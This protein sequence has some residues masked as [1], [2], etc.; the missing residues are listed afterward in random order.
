MT[1][2]RLRLAIVAFSAVLSASA[3]GEG[4]LDVQTPDVIDP[5]ALD[6]QLGI[7]SLHAGAVSEFGYAVDNGGA[8]GPALA[9]YSALFTDE[10]MHASTPPATREWDLRN[11]LASNT[12]S[13]ILFLNLQRARA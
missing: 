4:L 7:P 2:T 8:G 10:A 6:N 11:V 5:T 3:C 12:I 13:P 1:T 9:L